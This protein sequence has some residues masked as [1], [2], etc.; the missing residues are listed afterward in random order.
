MGW[1]FSFVRAGC[2]AGRKKDDV[3]V[4]N[5]MDTGRTMDEEKE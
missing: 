1:P 2:D 4:L 5:L 3:A